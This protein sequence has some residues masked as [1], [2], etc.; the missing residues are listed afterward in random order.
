MNDI[1][2]DAETREAKIERLLAER[3]ELAGKFDAVSRR[4]E[5]DRQLDDLAHEDQ[6]FAGLKP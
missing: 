5:I 2:E 3:R 4:D 6:P 1:P